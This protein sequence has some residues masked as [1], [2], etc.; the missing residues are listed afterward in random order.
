MNI[1]DIV[2]IVLVSLV[3]S[4]LIFYVARRLYLGKGLEDCSCGHKKG[5]DLVKEFYKQK[6]KGKI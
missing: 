2:I 5:S 1:A 6:S 4:A 3:A